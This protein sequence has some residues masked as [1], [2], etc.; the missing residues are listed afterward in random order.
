MF[1]G[2]KRT[3]AKRFYMFAGRS[4]PLSPSSLSRSSSSLSVH[5]W[6]LPLSLLLTA[7]RAAL[8]PSCTATHRVRVMHLLQHVQLCPEVPDGHV[9]DVLQ[10]LDRHDGAVPPRLV[11]YTKLSLA[12]SVAPKGRQGMTSCLMCS[13]KA[14]STDAHRTP[15]QSDVVQQ[16]ASVRDRRALSMLLICGL[17]CDGTH[18]SSPALSAR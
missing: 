12:C 13:L 6:P 16:P 14:R 11:H 10:D 4:L 5:C 7:H 1:V 17:K 15:R 3:N 8:Q 2:R 18:Q 9:T